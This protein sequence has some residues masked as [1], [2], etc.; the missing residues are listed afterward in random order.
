M[1]PAPVR[2]VI[3]WD[4]NKRIPWDSSQ[5]QEA[6]LACRGA[7]KAAPGGGGSH[8]RVWAGA[9]PP[10]LLP[11]SLGIR[12]LPEQQLPPAHKI[13]NPS[14][15]SRY[16]NLNFL[17]LLLC[18]MPNEVILAASSWSKKLSVLHCWSP[19]GLGL[20][21]VAGYCM[22]FG[23]C[24]ASIDRIMRMRG[25]S[26]WPIFDLGISV[27]TSAVSSAQHCAVLSWCSQRQLSLGQL[28]AQCSCRGFSW[29][30]SCWNK[31]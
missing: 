10:V 13:M 25:F 20:F 9:C 17:P 1:L 30:S 7:G 21:M 6:G 2:L 12:N 4:R 31:S 27:K 29:H 28:T 24:A 26:F 18:L 22:Y 5:S 3:K 11:L 23:V 15:T 14:H 8:S 16:K 19:L